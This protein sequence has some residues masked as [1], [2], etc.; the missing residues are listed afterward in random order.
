M[1]VIYYADDE[2]ALRDIVAAFLESEG[3]EVRAMRCWRR[4]ER[5]R[6]SWCSWIL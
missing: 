5:R 3:H 4:F 1:A 6:A 2:Q